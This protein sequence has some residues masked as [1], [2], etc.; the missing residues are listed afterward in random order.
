MSVDIL[1]KALEVLGERALCDRCLG[2]FFARLGYG[3]SNRERG[4]SLKR[5][6]VMSYHAR[7][8]GGDRDALE[9]FLRVAPNIGVQALGLYSFLLVRSLL[10]ESVVFAV[11]GLRGS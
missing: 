6:I 4:D 10:L 8:K 7:I 9:E 3:W 5:L 2:R 11:V 1:G